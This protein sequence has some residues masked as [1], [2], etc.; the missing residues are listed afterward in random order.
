M[1][2][3]AKIISAPDTHQNCILGLCKACV[4]EPLA[5]IVNG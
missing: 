2:L 4:M 1:Y 3:G 5:E